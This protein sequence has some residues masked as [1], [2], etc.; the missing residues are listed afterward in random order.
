MTSSSSRT[1]SPAIGPSRSSTARSSSGAAPGATRMPRSAAYAGSA[2]SPA[3]ACVGEERPRLRAR[4]AARRRRRLLLVVREPAPL[5]GLRAQARAPLAAVH[6]RRGLWIAPAA[7]GFD[8]RLVGGTSIVDR[9]GGDTLRRELDAAASSSPD[10]IGVISWNEFSENTFV[11]P[12]RAY[13]S[14]ALER[15]RRHAGRGAARCRELR[16]RGLRLRHGRIRDLLRH[17]RTCARDVS[18]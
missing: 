4:R 6:A 12:S 13:G 3:G 15:D 5:H 9:H 16:L 18:D 10:A 2:R 14:T 11:E 8:S 17:H 1:R 7:P